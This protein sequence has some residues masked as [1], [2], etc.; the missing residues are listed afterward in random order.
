M[1]SFLL[2]LKHKSQ[3]D[4]EEPG[5]NSGRIMIIG[6]NIA[7]HLFPLIEKSTKMTEQRQSKHDFCN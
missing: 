4:T 3:H 7:C 2:K 6:K 1:K 5:T